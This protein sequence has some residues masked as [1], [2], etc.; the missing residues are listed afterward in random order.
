MLQD[1]AA[2]MEKLAIQARPILHPLQRILIEAISS[3]RMP[4]RRQMDADLMAHTGRDFH[5]EQAVDKAGSQSIGFERLEFG[6]G[7][8]GLV[9]FDFPLT[10][11][12]QH[13]SLLARVVRNRR[14]NDGM[15][16]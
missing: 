2:Q 14:F 6:V 11:A 15:R 13:F 9:M 3:Q 16:R 4:D 12:N 7:L 5:A 10:L 8:T 1:N